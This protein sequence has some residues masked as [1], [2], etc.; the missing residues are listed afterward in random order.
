MRALIPRIAFC[1]AAL[2][3]AAPAATAQ[4]TL[5][6]VIKIVV[7]F[8]PGASND[9]I[10][11]AIAVPLAKRLDI[12]VIVE[13][14]PGAAGVIGADAVAKSPRDASVLLLTSS[15]FLT[16]AATQPQLPYDPIGTFAP[17]AM[18]G[19]GPLLLAVSSSTPYK[20]PAD[21]LVAARAKPGGLN[22]GS[23]GVG[24]IGHLAT[25]LLDDA[26]KIQMTHVPY[27]GAANAVTDLASGQIQV[28]LSSYS[29]LSPLIKAGKVKALAVT[30]KHAHPAFADLPPLAATVPGYAIDIWV[31]VLAPAGTA[32]PLIERLN[33]EINEIAASPEL[34]TILEPDGT[35]PTPLSAATFAA[36]MKEEL[37]QWK[38]IA[39]DHKIVAE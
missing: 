13:N 17:V 7:P 29:T 14:K 30:S 35:V 39:A 27:K 6:K 1:V 22:Y 37:A 9:V 18:I 20:T 28:M 5:P 15:T 2:F 10:A 3:G 25:Q 16:A 36:R 24:S 8:S 19:Q 34:G 11:R 32:A 4:I 12:T 26:A 31:G 38:K 33:R 21:V 23:A